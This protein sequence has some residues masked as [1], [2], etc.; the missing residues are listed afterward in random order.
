[1][2]DAGGLEMHLP[3]L[4]DEASAEVSV[5]PVHPIP[6]VEA[7]DLVESSATNEHAGSRHPVDRAA[8]PWT[9]LN[10]AG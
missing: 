2:D 10:S 6:L 5:F 4:V 8:A 7:A 1:M 9:R 3:A